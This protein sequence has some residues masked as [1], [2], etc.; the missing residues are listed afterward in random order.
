M[1]RAV[2]PLRQ[3]R[4]L[5][6]IAKYARR[7]LLNHTTQLGVMNSFN[8]INALRDQYID[9][10]IATSELRPS[11]STTVAIVR[12]GQGIDDVS[13]V[14]WDATAPFLPSG[15]E[16]RHK[17]TLGDALKTA[18]YFLVVR[19]KTKLDIAALTRLLEQALQEGNE[20]IGLWEPRYLPHGQDKYYDPVTGYTNWSSID[21]SLLT[22][23]TFSYAKALMSDDG[24][25]IF[26]IET[27]YRIRSAGFLLQYCP[28]I[29][30]EHQISSDQVSLRDYV[31]LWIRY[32][33]LRT[34][35][36]SREGQE[37]SIYYPLGGRNLELRRTISASTQR[38]DSPDASHPKVSIIVRTYRGRET[39]LKQALFSII[40][41]TYD[42]IE[43]VVVEDGGSHQEKYVSQV[44]SVASGCGKSILYFSAEKVGRSQTG[45]IGLSKASGEYIGFLD[46]DDLLFRDH[47]ETLVSAVTSSKKDAAYA[48][49][50]AIKTKKENNRNGYIETAVVDPKA[51]NLEYSYTILEKENIFPIQS[52][53]FH[54]SR[55]DQHGGFDTSLEHLEDWNLWLRYAYQADFA[56]VRQTTS[57]FRVPDED[58]ILAERGKLMELA[59]DT[60]KQKAY[61][62]LATFRTE[63][64]D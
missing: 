44:S 57:M 8:A 29:I 3:S 59:R 58:A 17:S 37:S 46:D 36:A 25:I 21:H 33:P 28:D 38:Y 2:S 52:I 60:A 14:E 45:N 62:A 1:K 31:A 53:I 15:L 51:Y 50:W 6:Q 61:D 55:Y 32:N 11:P 41:Q 54:R 24:A 7:A 13:L 39:L 63:A 12:I 43:I 27:S 18:S 4:T 42:N 40:K 56:F 20:H 64:Q 49:S 34:G 47:V 19:G 10:R 23:E 48:L 9:H 5:R 35:R 26:D 22:R 16:P 30:V